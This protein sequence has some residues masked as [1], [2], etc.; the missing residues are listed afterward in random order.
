MEFTT[1]VEV[2]TG[3]ET[4]TKLTNYN[5]PVYETDEDAPNLCES[6]LNYRKKLVRTER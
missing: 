2:S 5:F 4:F 6:F 3:G 1:L